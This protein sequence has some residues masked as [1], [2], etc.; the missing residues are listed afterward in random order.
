[1]NSYLMRHVRHLSDD[2]QYDFLE[3]YRQSSEINRSMYRVVQI[4]KQTFSGVKPHLTARCRLNSL[5]DPS[6]DMTIRY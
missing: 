5:I 6:A 2:L 4:V 3:F 1:M